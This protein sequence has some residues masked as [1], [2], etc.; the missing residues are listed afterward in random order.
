M[1]EEFEERWNF[2]LCC[3]AL[4]G[5]HIR[6]TGT[7]SSGSL[8][9]N[10]KGAHSL[11]FLAL[12]D[13]KYRFR[14]INV[15]G[16]GRTSDGGIFANSTFGKALFDGTFNPPPDRHLPDADHH[17]PQPYVIRADEA[18]P[19]CRNLM[20]LFP[21]DGSLT[22]EQ[23]VFNYR[24]SRARLVVHDTFEFWSGQWRMFKRKL[25]I[26]MGVV[27][28][29]VKATCVL[30]NFMLG[31]GQTTAPGGLE[32]PLQRVQRMGANFTDRETTDARDVFMPYFSGEGAVAW[33]PTE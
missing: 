12:V 33:Q 4:D 27:V 15:W 32:E 24:V 28:K 26:S 19:L 8:F 25:N 16:Y 17:G 3:G 14:V 9:C 31:G 13:A 21:G 10:Y 1:A 5:K 22:R 30:H 23:Q 7:P 18:F 11:A 29:C 6:F 2:P 20:S